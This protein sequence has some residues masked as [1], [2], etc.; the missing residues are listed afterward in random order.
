MLNLFMLITYFELPFIRSRVTKLV[1]ISRDSLLS[2]YNYSKLYTRN[3]FTVY[4][5]GRGFDS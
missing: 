4:T 1:L 3:S 5:E 2:L